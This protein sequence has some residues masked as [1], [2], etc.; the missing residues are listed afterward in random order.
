MK[1]DPIHLAS[2]P[3]A[4]CMRLAPGARSRTGTL[5][6]L[7]LLAGCGIGAEGDFIGGRDRDLCAD[8]I[9]ACPSTAGCYL[10]AT[11]YT[12][13]RFPG[14]ISFLVDAPADS[15]IAVDLFFQ[16]QQANGLDTRIEI[17]EPGCFE[18]YEYVVDTIDLFREAGSDRILN[19]PPQQVVVDG[20]HLV[21]VAS[22][23]VADVLIRADVIVSGPN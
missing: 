22:D 6:L 12:E 11:R 4:P 9:P 23:A 10:G 13:T 15:E 7:A 18:T 3:S 16:T 21:V 20:D 8:V 5:G 14:A 1:N 19:F 17:S 2:T